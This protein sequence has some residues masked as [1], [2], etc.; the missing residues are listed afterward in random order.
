MK[1]EYTEKN[2]FLRDG[3]KSIKII[4]SDLDGTLADCSHRQHLVRQK[5]K[6][7]NKFFAGT[8]DDVP[9]MDIFD[10]VMKDYL[11]AAL[12]YG[13]DNTYLVIVSARPEYTRAA[14][15][16]WLERH[17]MIHDITAIIMRGDSDRRDDDVVKREVYD[18]LLSKNDVLRVYDDRPRVVRMWREL[19]L[20]VVD[21]GDG[22]EF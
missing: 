6:D 17:G 5:E 10:Q 22:I 3:N 11:N 4:V 9:R 20:D 16:E 14:T 7:W 13:V 1:I 12:K 18:N 15:I 21:C 19:G 2:S 8:K